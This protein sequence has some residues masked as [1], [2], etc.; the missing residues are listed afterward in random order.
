VERLPP[1]V[2]MLKEEL[3]FQ[4]SLGESWSFELANR[5]G[6]VVKPLARDNRSKSVE[7]WKL[8][9]MKNFA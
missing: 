3:L 7:D 9:N 6:T 5:A 8:W 2:F 1:S 4:S